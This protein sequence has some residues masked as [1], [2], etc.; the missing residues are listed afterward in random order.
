MNVQINIGE[1]ETF[2]MNTKMPHATG[3]A[4]T[5]IEADGSRSD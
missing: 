3:M 5:V 4:K 2:T 1:L